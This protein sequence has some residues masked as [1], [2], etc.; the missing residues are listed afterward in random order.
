MSNMVMPVPIP[1]LRAELFQLLGQ[2]PSGRLTTY[3]DLA[4]ALGDKRAA[5]WVGE[6]LVHHQ[7]NRGCLCHRVV[8]AQGEIGL[9][10]TGNPAEKAERLRQEGISIARQK[11]DLTS[12]MF[13][14]EFQSH[15]PLR[16]LMR[17]QAIIRE[18]AQQQP[19]SN[20]PEVLVGLDVA[21]PDPQ[22][23]R[24]AAVVLDAK[25]LETV[26]EYQ[27]DSPVRFP[28]IPGY[29]TYREL[30]VLWELWEQ[31]QPSLPGNIICMIDGNGML[32]PRRCGIAVTFGVLAD[33]PTLG[34][35]KSLLCG[36]IE[37][38]RNSVGATGNVV[39]QGE[40][41]GAVMKAREHSRA[42]YVSIG[43]RMTLNDAIAWANSSLTGHRTPEPIFRADR[44]SKTRVASP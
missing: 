20:P 25:T 40:I 43:H 21:Y 30:P 32:H 4:Q 5:R 12:R 41:I 42:V 9:F 16:A 13:A 6:V 28:Y 44:L 29:L 24:A 18:A 8:R 3:G 26:A 22:T 15:F 34:I 1:D 37:P 27:Q 33:V 7:H 35:G 23:A 17:H 2:V 11:A 19:L 38:A 31:I 39:D 10:I 14:D 36:Q